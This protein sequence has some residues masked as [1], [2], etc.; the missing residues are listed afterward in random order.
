MF[1]QYY[2]IYVID[3]IITI[4]RCRDTKRRLPPFIIKIY[5]KLALVS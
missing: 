5:K 1:S 4:V 3:I 2:L